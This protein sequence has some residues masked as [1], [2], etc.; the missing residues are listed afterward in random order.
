MTL[1]RNPIAPCALTLAV[2][3]A[4]CGGGGNSV[5]PNSGAS[6]TLAMHRS[7]NPIGI[8]GGE[9][10]PTT[11]TQGFNG[12]AIPKGSWIWFSSVMTPVGGKGA[13]D[14]SMYYSKITFNDGTKNVE[15]DGPGMNLN[16][17]PS[18]TQAYLSYDG[19]N[20]N[21]NEITPVG[22]SGND[23]LNGIAYY[24]PNGLP[25]GIKN[26]TWSAQFFSPTGQQLH[27]QWAAA[28]YTNFS[29]DYNVLTQSVKPLDDNHFPP[30]NSDHAGTP[31]AYKQYVIGGAT[32]GGGSNFT[33]SY[34]PTVTVTPCICS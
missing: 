10:A 31:E 8:N 17:L 1:R 4:G 2:L 7:G 27:W 6:N 19:Y 30:K 28:V 25:G 24:V 3:V 23:F 16:M 14:V 21:W 20:N 11:N 15:I 18:F 33:G 12:T 5:V 26:V 22:T 29:S 32:G 9:C 34:G 13:F